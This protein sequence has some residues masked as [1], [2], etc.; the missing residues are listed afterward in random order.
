MKLQ[1]EPHTY[2]I[3]LISDEISDDVLDTLPADRI[4]AA[5]TVVYCFSTFLDLRPVLATHG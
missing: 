4:R 1:E 2:K 3:Q 5:Q